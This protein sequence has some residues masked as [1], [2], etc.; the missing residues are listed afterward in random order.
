[1]KH[2]SMRTFL[3]HYLPRRIGT[4]MQALMRGFEPDSEMMRA[5]TR[6]GRW[7]DPRRPRELTD[8]QKAS[9]E[10][11][12][13]LMEAIQRRDQLAMQLACQP[14]KNG[15]Q[16]EK[17]DRLK[18]AVTNTRKRLLYDLR[19]RVRQ[20]FDDEQAVVDTE[21]QL[22]G[23]ALH[24]E[25]TKEVLQKEEQMLPE[26]VHLLEKLMTWPT[27]DS[28][29]AEWRRRNEAVEAVRVY[30]D[31]LEGGPRRGRR[32]TAVAR[33]EEVT[34]ME[35]VPT[36]SVGPLSERAQAFQIAEHHIKKAP[37][38]ELLRCFQCFSDPEQADSRRLKRYDYHR[39]LVRHF[40]DWHLD[41]RRCNYCGE[42]GE[43]LLQM[44]WQR[45]VQ[46]AHRLIS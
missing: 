1:M 5:V 18:K 15:N 34:V 27:S 40:R 42:K 43:F 10:Q 20:E 38:K 32:P 16:L 24:D 14:Q 31:V 41:D 25:E 39:N 19:I 4:D 11:E 23:T 7:L 37:Q 21:R 35:D 45:H 29:E 44:H 17:L 2:A 12:P 30:C 8:Q 6:M 33:V 36:E 28:I 13:E 3:N 9:V 26:Q 22:S 46:D